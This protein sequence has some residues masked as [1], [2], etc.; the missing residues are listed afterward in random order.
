M[1]DS[2]TWA[3]A[4]TLVQLS[5]SSVPVVS[6]V[7]PPKDGIT[8]PPRACTAAMSAP[9]LPGAVAEIGVAVF[10]FQS[11]VHEPGWLVCRKARVR[12]LAPEAADSWAS[13]PSVLSKVSK[14]GAYPGGGRGGRP[15]ACGGATAAVPVTAAAAASTARQAERWR[16]NVRSLSDRSQKV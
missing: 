11:A 15:A 8:F 6:A 9:R 1:R 12:N 7:N 2:N 5:A 10:P 3:I 13:P 4:L 16:L 14:Y